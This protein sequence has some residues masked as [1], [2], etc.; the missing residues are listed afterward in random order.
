MR[1]TIAAIL[2]CSILYGA[3]AADAPDL[4]IAGPDHF[5]GK[6]AVTIATRRDGE[7]HY[8]VDG[9]PPTADS[10][11]YSGPIAIDSTVTIKAFVIDKF[12]NPVVPT[13]YKTILQRNVRALMPGDWLMAADVT[14][15]NGPRFAPDNSFIGWCDGGTN[16]AFGPIRLNS[17]KINSI[18]VLAGVSPSTAGGKMLVHLDVPDGPMLG[19]MTFENTGGFDQFKIQRFRVARFS[20]DHMLYFVFEGRVGICSL[21]G[22]RFTSD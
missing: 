3:A 16:M 13:V 14:E 22:F 18:E 21:K 12:G 8:T 1:I 2:S 19:A 20:G 6:A 11:L 17:E 7:I 4:V 15:L 5:S 9:S 10:P